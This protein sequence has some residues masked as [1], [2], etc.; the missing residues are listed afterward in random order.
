MKRLFVLV[1]AAML[2]VSFSACKK[3]PE[4]AAKEPIKVGVVL[5]LTGKHAKFGEIERQ[6]FEMAAEEINAKL[7]LLIEDTQGKPD[8]GRSAVEKLITQDKVVMIGGGYSSSVTYAAAGVTVNKGFPFLVNTGSA[9]K[10]T[11]PS[12]FTPSGQRADNLR[13]KLKKEKDAA[14]KAELEKE[15]ADL[16][17]KADGE[18]ND[19]MAKFSIFRLNPPVSE[20]ASG[21]EGFLADVV[22][23]KTAVIL[24]E[25]SLFGTKGAK[26]FEK[27]CKKLNIKVLMKESYDAGAVDFKPLLAK[28]KKA[29]PDV[30]YNTHD[31]GHTDPYKG[32]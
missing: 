12:S 13:K 5:P 14:K 10:I 23:P 31:K 6:S 30:V 17:K 26:A 32:V 8:V 11:E 7:E 22:K 18:A 4:K 2:L 1:V 29:N 21:L 28:V 3:A 25:N 16:T 15:I 9:D 24:N 19:L 20:Y 27:S